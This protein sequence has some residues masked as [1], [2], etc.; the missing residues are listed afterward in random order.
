MRRLLFILIGFFITLVSSAQIPQYLPS[1]GLLVWLPF[2]GDALDESGNGIN[3]TVAGPDLTLDRFGNAN[4]AY[5]F[6]GG[7]D[8]IIMA[9]PFSEGVNEMTIMAWFKPEVSGAPS[10]QVISL[11]Q[12]DDGFNLNDGIAYFSYYPEPSNV[13][14]GYGTSN[15]NFSSVIIDNPSQEWH[16]A[17]M[18]FNGAEVSLYM[19]SQLLGT[20]SLSTGE[21]ISNEPFAIGNLESNPVQG[22]IGQIDDFAIWNRALTTNEIEQLFLSEEGEEVCLPSSTPIDGLVAYY[23]FC[24]SAQDFSGNGLNAVINGAIFSEDRNGIENSC[25]YFDGVDDY[26]SVAHSPLLEFA[27]E[28]EM[29]VSYWVKLESYPPGSFLDIIFSKQ[30]GSGNS[31]TGWNINQNSTITQSLTVGN[32]GGL[33]GIGV[34]LL[35]LNEW[36]NITVTRDNEFRR[37]YLNGELIDELGVSTAI[38][39]N[40][41]D[42]LIGKANWNNVNA[43]NFNGFLDE[44]ALYNRALNPNEV[45]L[46]FWEDYC[47]PCLNNYRRGDLDCTGTVDTGDLLIFLT[48]YGQ[49]IE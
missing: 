2:N 48:E 9:S 45:N 21:Y 31:Q 8:R 47:D 11:W 42:L 44:I 19:D 6:G 26:L 27:D 32:T 13:R 24:G 25:M 15:T 10:D 38:G 3:G 29:S 17:I 16:C 34:G 14:V 49:V 33:E 37:A 22:F 46:L 30:S 40:N 5:D 41:L 39:A 1:N 18:T 43:Q 7:Q 4:A 23:P 20:S 12:Q 36:F 35:P 28:N